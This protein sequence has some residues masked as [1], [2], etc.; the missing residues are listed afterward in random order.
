M[1][2]SNVWSISLGKKQGCR[3]R[4][5]PKPS[6]FIIIVV[7]EEGIKGDQRTQ[8][9]QEGGGALWEPCASPEACAFCASPHFAEG[10]SCG[11]IQGRACLRHAPHAYALFSLLCSNHT[12]DIPLNNQLVF[13]TIQLVIRTNFHCITMT[14][15]MILAYVALE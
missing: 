2:F 9:G 3:F 7:E 5:N 14:T 15:N 8:L 4:N 12:V 13:K 10:V 6:I 11:L 1:R